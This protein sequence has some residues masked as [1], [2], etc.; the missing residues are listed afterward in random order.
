MHA[1]E[2]QARVGE[3]LACAQVL[4][5]AYTGIGNQQPI[6]Y[7]DVLQELLERGSRNTQSLSRSNVMISKKRKIR[8]QDEITQRRVSSIITFGSFVQI[9]RGWHNKRSTQNPLHENFTSEVN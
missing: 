2:Y 8:V 9:P 3:G 6:V 7:Y 4:K 5:T 1:P